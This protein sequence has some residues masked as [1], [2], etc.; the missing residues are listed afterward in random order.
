MLSD[1]CLR[2]LNILLKS[3]IRIF[4]TVLGVFSQTLSGNP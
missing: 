3:V 4:W 1:S 2:F